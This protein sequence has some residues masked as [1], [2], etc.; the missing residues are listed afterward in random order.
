MHIGSDTYRTRSGHSLFEFGFHRRDNGAWRIYVLS[1]PSYGC[2]ASG[3]HA[4]HRL[5]DDSGYYVC[6][7][8]RI[9]N[10]REAKFVA[11][12]WSELTERY[13][14]TGQSFG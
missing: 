14:A 9:A 7:Q 4:T 6:W 2:R 11:Q 3:L 8:G 5:R 12:V 1:Q 13:I 10:L